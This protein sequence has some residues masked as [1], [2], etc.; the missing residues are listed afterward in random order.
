[1]FIEPIGSALPS[2]FGVSRQG[3]VNVVTRQQENNVVTVLG[4]V[5]VATV[6]Q[7]A[8]SVARR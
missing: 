1:V 2:T 3:G 6:R 5:P 7:I 4:E 8:H